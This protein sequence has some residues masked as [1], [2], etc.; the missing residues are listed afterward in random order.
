MRRRCNYHPP[1]GKQCS[2][3]MNEQHNGTSEVV[4]VQRQPAP[5]SRYR[6]QMRADI[7]HYAHANQ[8]EV[9]EFRRTMYGSESVFADATYLH[10]LYEDPERVA[11]AQTAFWLY[12]K[13]S[14]LHAHQGGLRTRLK[15]GEQERDALWLLDLMVSPKFRMRGVGV[16][17]TQMACETADVALGLEVS[18]DARKALLRD[19][20]LDL[21]SVPLYVRPLDLHAVLR[22]RGRSG[23]WA[24]LG[25]AGNIGLNLFDTF[26]CTNRLSGLRMDEVSCFDARADQVW[27]QAS[28]HYPVICRRDRTF[29]NWR[30]A[31]F[32]VA[33]RYQRFLFIDND[34]AIGYAV[35][36]VGEHHGLRAGYIVDFLCPPRYTQALVAQCVR[37]LREQDA[38]IVYCLHNSPVASKAFAGLGFAR[39]QSN[40]PLMLRACNLGAEQLAVVRDQRNWFITAGDS[41]ADRPREG[42]VFAGDLQSA[43]SYEHR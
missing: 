10:W 13:A 34:A 16:L 12:R 25:R 39:R 20:W 41:D 36:R 21:G 32:P 7:T 18:D 37:V 14:Q 6:E 23:I 8:A 27:E 5:R 33:N 2:F 35:L 31:R 4:I 40:W 38:Q 22:Q 9:L 1:H 17:L 11:A 24:G 15:I 28:P 42:T 43:T 19:G 26:A 30:W 3:M 29:L